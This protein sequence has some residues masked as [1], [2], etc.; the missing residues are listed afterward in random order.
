[1]I[2]ITVQGSFKPQTTKQ[3]SAMKGGHAQAVAKAIEYLSGKFM[4]DAISLD[5]ELH[6]EGEKPEMGFGKDV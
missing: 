2:T 3:F 6:E 5:H 1:M 4:A